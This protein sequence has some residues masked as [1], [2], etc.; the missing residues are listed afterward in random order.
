[1]VWIFLIKLRRAQEGLQRLPLRGGEM[2]SNTGMVGTEEVEWMKGKDI[3]YPGSI[4]IKHILHGVDHY[5]T[6][7]I[8]PCP[9]PPLSPLNCSH[10]H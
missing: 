3:S 4:L 8:L 7:S 6:C 1:M 2:G 5:C 9:P 10:F